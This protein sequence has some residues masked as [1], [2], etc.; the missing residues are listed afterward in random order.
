MTAVK[1]G[2]NILAG[3]LRS[4]KLA[5]AALAA[6]A[7]GLVA[8]NLP[9]AGRTP[10][11]PEATATYFIDPTLLTPA[12]Q[13]TGTPAATLE[14]T[15]VASPTGCGYWA[16]FVE[17][18]TIPDGTEIVAGTSFEKTW[19]I[20]NIGCQAWPPGTRLYFWGEEQLDAPD[21]VDVPAI[22]VN[23][24]VDI[25]VTF[26]APLEPGEYL[27]NWQLV[28]PDGS[29]IGAHVFV[30]IM[31][32]PATPT[33]TPVWTPLIGTWTNDAPG[34]SGITRLMIWAEEG[35]LYARMWRMEGA[36]ETDWGE[37]MTPSSDADDGLLSLRWTGA[38]NGGAADRVETQQ[39]TRLV[40]GRLQITGQVNLSDPA[41]EDYNYIIFL[42]KTTP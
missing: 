14:P 37:T 23:T 22:P 13:E 17:D 2:R 21:Y 28:A 5:G 18:V 12:V 7:S 11:P 39:I 34:V 41:A 30:Q 16:E 32:V 35:M 15:I 29:W 38:E 27:S 20:R 31:V 9:G 1:A 25:S 42:E 26:T 10:A 36:V 33:P 24:T 3:Q 8:C 6:T 4:I 40:D 19:R